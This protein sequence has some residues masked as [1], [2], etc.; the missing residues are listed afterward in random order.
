M[1]HKRVATMPSS[2]G[3]EDGESHNQGQGQGP[4][5]ENA[6]RCCFDFTT[7]SFPTTLT[8]ICESAFQSSTSLENVDFLHTNLQELGECIFAGCTEL[9]SMTIPDSLQTF[10]KSVFSGCRKLFP[11]NFNVNFNVNHHPYDVV[12]FLRSLQN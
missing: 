10:G 7:V 4:I 6:F 9:T 12:N 1:S 5:G 8:L 3:G 2:R 11:T